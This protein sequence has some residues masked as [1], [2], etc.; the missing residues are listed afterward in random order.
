MSITK[1]KPKD[2]WL[3]TFYKKTIYG[4]INKCVFI[5]SWHR[6]NLDFF[7]FLGQQDGS[8]GKRYL[9]FTP[10]VESHSQNSHKGGR[11]EGTR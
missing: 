10:S 7:F 5:N 6:N 3:L 9:S 4:S 11:G 1:Y 8:L 2:S